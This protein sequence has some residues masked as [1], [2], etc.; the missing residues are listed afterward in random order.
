MDSAGHLL[1]NYRSQ[2]DFT[3]DARLSHLNM[4]NRRRYST[5]DNKKCS[6]H[7]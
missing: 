4:L 1:E 5:H 6:I 7:R 2:S 3:L